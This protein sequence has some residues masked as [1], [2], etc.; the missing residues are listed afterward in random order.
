MHEVILM[1]VLNRLTNALKIPL[2][3]LLIQLSVAKLDLFVETAPGG[4]LQYHIGDILLFLVVV[5]D[6]L[7]DIGVDEFM[8]HI[9]LLLC[10]LVVDLRVRLPLP[11]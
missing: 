3:Q 6:E 10:V 8:M 4:V 1:Q 11:S 7:Y 5:I 2:D 9:D